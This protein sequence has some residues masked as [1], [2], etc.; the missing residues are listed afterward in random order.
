MGLFH[1]WVKIKN[2]GGTD[3]SDTELENK[4]VAD[5]ET[6]KDFAPI[7]ISKIKPNEPLVADFFI[8]LNEK[9]IKFKYKGDEIPGEKY[10]EFLAKNLKELFIH[11]EHVPDVAAWLEEI[12]KKSIDEMTEKVGEENRE[13]A[14]KREEVSELVYETFS[15]E[16]LSNETVDLLQEQAEQFVE[17]VKNNEPS[18]ALIAKLQK[19]N[20]TVADH[21]VN[22]AN[23]SVFLAMTL[24]HKHHR[25]LENVYMG[26]L[27]HDYGKAKIPP[28]VLKDK[29][30]TKANMAMKEHPIKGASALKKFKG[31]S[32]PVLD[33]VMQHHEQENGKGYPLG[34]PGKEIYG[35]AKIV[36]IANIFDNVC[37]ENQNKSEDEM[38]KAA[39]KSLEYD[40][41]RRIEPAILPRA[42]D[43][44]KLA[45]GNYVRE[46]KL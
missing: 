44:L 42:V 19:V 1:F 2:C 22:V 36:S 17:K 9:F 35:L 37:E 4:Y 12:K 18:A 11:I 46:R 20:G 6:E 28:E 16:E 29:N 30:T 27:L 24:G 7:P 32:Q 41:G 23:L 13:L 5:E 25:I 21:C 26:A 33:I 15:D 31:I 40:R 14:E 39:I 45:F 3:L 38:Y 43:A 10:H 34:M 8:K